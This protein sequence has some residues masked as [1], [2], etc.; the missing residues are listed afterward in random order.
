MIVGAFVVVAAVATLVRWQLGEWLPRPTGTFVANMVG[1]FVLGWVSGS[2]D[3][4]DTIV[5]V[6]ALGSLTTFST[7]SLELVELWP[8][9][10]SAAAGYLALTVAAGVGLAWLGLALA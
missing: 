1:A 2:S 7:L 10:R 5:G 6:A 4:T 8:V 3:S 9:R